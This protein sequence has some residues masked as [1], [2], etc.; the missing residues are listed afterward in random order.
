M[1]TFAQNKLPAMRK[2]RTRQWRIPLQQQ[3]KPVDCALTWMSVGPFGRVD[4]GR[5]DTDEQP[6]IY[7]T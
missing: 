2:P 6:L 7:S 3:T 5:G 1:L 4:R